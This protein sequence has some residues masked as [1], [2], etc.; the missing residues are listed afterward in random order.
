MRP[1]MPKSRL[2]PVFLAAAV[3]LG[4]VLLVQLALADGI[5]RRRPPPEREASV[6]PA[7]PDVPSLLG[8][9]ELPPSLEGPC[10]DREQALLAIQTASA[11]VPMETVNAALANVSG[12]D[13]T[14]P[15][16]PAA[17]DLSNRLRADLGYEAGGA[18][19]ATVQSALNDATQFAQITSDEPT[20]AI[21]P[22][23]DVG[24]PGPLSPSSSPLVPAGSP[25]GAN[26]SGYCHLNGHGCGRG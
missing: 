25:G 24:R 9:N 17:A 13:Q 11:G 18:N 10:L 15:T 1:Q 12:T 16:D 20:G 4:S 19:C 7:S 6:V 21:G 26:G 8:A 3:S 2:A 14:P 5:E 22:T 23:G